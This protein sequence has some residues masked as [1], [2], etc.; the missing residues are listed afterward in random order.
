M[1][2]L[3]SCSYIFRSPR[4]RINLL[5]TSVLLKIEILMRAYIASFWPIE[6]RKVALEAELYVPCLKMLCIVVALVLC[7]E[8]G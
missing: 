1:G 7:G 4:K 8:C 6:I 3:L 2:N 5:K